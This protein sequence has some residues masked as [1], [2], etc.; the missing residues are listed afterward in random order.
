MGNSRVIDRINDRGQWKMGESLYKRSLMKAMLCAWLAGV[1]LPSLFTASALGAGEPVI[2]FD[3]V[4]S[5]TG[6]CSVSSAD[7]VPDPGCPGGSHPVNQFSRPMSVATD[8]Y[9]DIFVANHGQAPGEARIDI[10]NPEGRLIAEIAEAGEDGVIEGGVKDIAVDSDGN[11]YV[12]NNQSELLRYP[13]TKYE[14]GTGE[15]DYTKTPDKVGPSSFATFMGLA[16]DA[17]NQHVFTSDGHTIVEYSS[18]TEENKVIDETIGAGIISQPY[19]I[20]LAVD[21]AKGL[22]YVSDYKHSGSIPDPSVIRIFELK[23]PHA[24]VG[25]IDGSTTPEGKFLGGF[26]SVAV[27]EGT[28][29][30][31][32]YDGEGE[33]VVYEFTKDG[34]YISTIDHNFSYVFGAEI[35]ID[36]GENSPNGVLNPFGRYLFVPSN[37]SGTGH[38]FAF[39]PPEECT[40]VIKGPSVTGVTESEADLQAEI[41]PCNLETTYTFEYTTQQRFDEEGFA[42]ASVAGEGQIAA[43]LAP[44]P[45]S[46]AVTELEPGTAYRFR[47]IASNEAGDAEAEAQFST[48]PAI[49]IPPCPNDGVRTG[50]AALLPDCRAYELVTP[51]D[52]NARTPM[53]IGRLGTYFATRAASP[54]GNA[55]SFEIQ[56]GTLPGGEG[57]GSFAGDPYLATR[58]DEGWGTAYVGPSG[59]EAPAA[60]P[61][62]NSPDQGYSLWSTAGGL[63][64]AAIEGKQTNYVR[65]PDGHSALV[66]RGSLGTDPRAVGRLISGGGGHIVFVSGA[67]GEAVQLEPNA[68]PAGTKAIYDR[69]ADEITHVVSLLPGEVTPL[70]GENATYEGASLDGRGIAFSIGK[71]LYLRFD[72]QETYEAG[73]SV[74]FA[75]IAE[76]GARIFY[77]EGGDL[78]AFDAEAEETIQFSESGDVTPVNVAAEGTAAYFVSLS[79]LTGGEE[80]PDGA[81]AQPGEENLYLSREGAVNFVGTVTQRDVEGELKGEPIGGLGLWTTAVG[82]S[83]YGVPGRFA[84]DP[85]RTTPDGSVL[86]FESRADLT[87]YDPEGHA[88]VYRFDSV[89]HV[90]QCISCNPTQ[91]AAASDASLQSIRQSQLDPEPFSSNGYVANIRSD[92]RR[93]FFQSSEPLVPTDV[94]RLQDV[95]EWED[96]GVGSCIQPGGCIYLI[97]SGQSNRNDYLYA[98]SDSGNDVFFRSPDLL[99]SADRDETPSIYDAR[100][101]GGFPNPPSSVCEGE[102]CNPGIPSPPSMLSPE[103]GTHDE[104]GP[105]KSCPKGKRTVMRNGKVSC[106]KKKHHKKRHHRRSSHN[107]GGNK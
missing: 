39:G 15:I 107:K 9:G 23:E 62:S 1:L 71:K 63:G 104:G 40:P 50:S 25:A 43:G 32:V 101:E 26:F 69:T 53:G 45:V 42:G 93:A 92:G 96:Q 94:D 11:L 74:T 98:V 33:N 55:V 31:F 82:S 52:T 61:G 56:G 58:G 24:E 60:L 19:G 28:G 2:E 8:S 12:I 79:V 17:A 10:F 106:I 59:G 22:V 18:A 83:Q 80:N 27:D 103:S 37:P 51:P 75:G 16:I 38:S 13:P 35:A 70:E 95:Y 49:S 102:G 7:S 36:N 67:E 57:T 86:L 34:E 48:Y 85:S 21:A 64:S 6:D 78:F 76:G 91:A 46:A 81:T 66:G 72:N 47:V 89:G 3:P 30:V 99:L 68:P 73:E 44:V 84:E 88:E 20:G 65:Y 41:N 90:L 87:G 54:A 100:V 77:L 29:N 14:P 5:L 97:S 105:V 4:L